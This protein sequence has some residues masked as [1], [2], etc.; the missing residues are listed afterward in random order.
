MTGSGNYTP[1][2]SVTL[3]ATAKT[4][5]VFV[6]WQD[7]TTAASRT[8]TTGAAAVTYT[9]YFTP[10]TQQW[11]DLGLPS[12][13]KWSS[14]NVG[15]TTAYGVGG[16]YAWGATATQSSYSSSSGPYYS[17]SGYTKYNATDGLTTL[18]PAD[19]IAYQTYGTGAHIPTFEDFE[20]LCAYTTKLAT[21]SIGGRTCVVFVGSNGKCIITP[22][23]GYKTGTATQGTSAYYWTSTLSYSSTSSAIDAM[24]TNQNCIFNGTSGEGRGYGF[25]IR[26]VKNP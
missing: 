6:C 23:C 19:D 11:V 10:N 20:E 21:V 3:K 17:S 24:M 15:A 1:G 4:G 5:Y 26:A 16:Y 9:A 14:T 8:V 25:N 7:G 18:Q 12:G 2:S 22:G 13:R